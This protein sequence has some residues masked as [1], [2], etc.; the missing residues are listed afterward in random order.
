MRG[1][2]FESERGK[3][4]VV[5]VGREGIAVKVEKHGSCDFFWFILKLFE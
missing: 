2:E 1:N 5:V 4:K 3:T